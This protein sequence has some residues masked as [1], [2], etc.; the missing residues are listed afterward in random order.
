MRGLAGRLLRKLLRQ[1]TGGQGKLL[2]FPGQQKSPNALIRQG[3]WTLAEIRGQL[4]GGGVRNRTTAKST[5]RIARLRPLGSQ[6]GTKGG[7]FDPRHAQGWPKQPSRAWGRSLNQAARRPMLFQ[8]VRPRPMSALPDHSNNVAP[9]PDPDA[10]RAQAGLRCDPVQQG[11]A[12]AG[13]LLDPVR[14]V[15][16]ARVPAGPPLRDDELADAERTFAALIAADCPTP[17]P[18]AGT[19]G[20]SGRTTF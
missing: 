10:C 16:A 3:F 11:T 5:N 17:A 14:L 9:A 19:T 2:H 6:P 1:A 12:T 4:F 13:G 8:T 18:R 15:G 20:E 7:A